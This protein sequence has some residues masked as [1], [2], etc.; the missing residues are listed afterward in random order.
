VKLRARFERERMHKNARP[1]VQMRDEG[2]RYTNFFAS[3]S[4]SPGTHCGKTIDNV[5]LT[6]PYE[7]IAR[8]WYGKEH[9]KTDFIF[10]KIK[11]K[12]RSQ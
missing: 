9:S 7:K 2:S 4:T 10:S 12:Y 3:C 8:V 6:C 1:G 11:T 5:Y